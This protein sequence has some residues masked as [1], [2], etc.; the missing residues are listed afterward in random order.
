MNPIIR[1][2]IEEKRNSLLESEAKEFCACYG[3]PVPKHKVAATVKQ[4]I[5]GAE[6]I[7]FPIAMKVLSK[8]IIH[9]SEAGC[10]ELNIKNE[11]EV[12]KA[13]NSIM[14]NALKFHPNA[15]INGVI[16]EE[17]LPKG[18]EVA[19]GALRDVEFG[20]TVMFGLG[21]IFIE[22]MKDVTFRVAPITTEEAKR[23]MRE[24]KTYRLLEGYRGQEPADI[25]TL[26]K[27]LETTSKIMVENEEINQIDL[28]PII[29]WKKG[30]KI[31][32]AKI[33]LN[34]H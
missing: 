5:E 17:L 3:L 31:A 26:A 7:G 1:R 24:V 27:I 25:E 10:V 11:E 32:D 19:V 18:I 22:I 16:I 29:T 15:E 30:A 20:P 28:N 4:A 9:K 14:H 34:P 2:A 12:K 13:F 8:D 6:A 21:G 23:M 33:L